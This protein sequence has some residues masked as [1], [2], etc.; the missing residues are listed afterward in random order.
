M[1]KKHHWYGKRHTEETKKKMSEARKRFFRNGGHSSFYGKPHTEEIKR[2][3]ALS[4]MG[5]KNWAKRPDVRKKIS[6]ARIGEGRWIEFGNPNWKGGTSNN[7]YRKRVLSR[8]NFT[9][10]HCGLRDETKG[11]L[12]I[13]HIKPRRAF[14]EL[15]YKMENLITLCPNCHK[16]KT[17]RDRELYP[18]KVN[19]Q[20]TIK[21][22]G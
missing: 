2:K 11:F 9:C 5:D 21:K 1:N 8:D 10:Q 7:Y 17:L 16:R 15:T 3:I 19:N 22:M 18:Q 14:P 6:D 20:H 12:D 4:R 13:D